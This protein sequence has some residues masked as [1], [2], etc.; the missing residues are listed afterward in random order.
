MANFD[1][2]RSSRKCSVS[3]RTFNV[4]EEFHSL[5]ITENDELVRRDIANEHWNGPPENCFGWWKSRVPDLQQ[6]RVY[7]APKDVLLAYFQHLVDRPV[8]SD[9]A[10]VMA[11]LL[12]QKKYLRIVDTIRRD[13]HEFMLVNNQSTKEQFEVEVKTIDSSRIAVLQQELADKL[14]TNIAPTE[15]SPVDDSPSEE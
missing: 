5:L 12:L 13:G 11:I 4:G 6:G 7:W 15:D 8:G 3:G 9:E 14:F 1:F 2:K 10:Y